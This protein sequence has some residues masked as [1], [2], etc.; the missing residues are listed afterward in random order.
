MRAVTSNF[1]TFSLESG[2]DAEGI[3]VDTPLFQTVFLP[4]LMQVNFFP[5]AFSIFP[6]LGQTAPALGAANDADGAERDVISNRIPKE[7]F[8]LI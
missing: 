6:T 8:R 3:E 7:T 5:P 2:D 4:D 1:E